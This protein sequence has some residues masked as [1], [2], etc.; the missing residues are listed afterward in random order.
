MYM[1]NPDNNDPDSNH[2]CFP[3]DFM[4]IVDLSTMEV[5]RIVRF[6]LGSD[7]AVTEVGSDV[8]HRRTKPHEAE[9][10]HR[11]QKNPPR[12]SLKPYQVIQ[13]EGASFTATDNLIEWEKWRFRVGFNWREGK[14]YT[15]RERENVH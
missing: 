9:Y 10:D 8:P 2:Y 15:K 6:P 1:R 14:F 7:Q 13:P 5:K 3:L 11:L 12:T 4:V